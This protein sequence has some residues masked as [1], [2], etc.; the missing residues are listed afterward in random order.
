MD[1]APWANRTVSGPP[2]RR[3]GKWHPDLGA[4]WITIPGERVNRGARLIFTLPLIVTAIGCALS[5][6]ALPGPLYKG[7]RTADWVAQALHEEDVSEAFEAVL[8]IGAPAV[9]FIARWGLHDK[10]NMFHFLSSDYLLP[11][12]MGIPG[13]PVG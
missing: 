3:L 6:P 4:E 9:P 1:R 2:A 11:F 10:V 8:Q 5:R 12:W 13:S 7:R